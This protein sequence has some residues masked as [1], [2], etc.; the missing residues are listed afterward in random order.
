LAPS[1]H[2]CIGQLLVEPLKESH[3]RFLTASDSWQWQQWGLVSTD[4]MY[5]QVGQSWMAHSSVSAPFFVPVLPL[6]RN[7][8]GIKTLRLKNTQK[9]KQ[10]L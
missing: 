3:T 1:I 9:Q 10:K 8:S 5:P 4:R 6:D 7:I 2:I